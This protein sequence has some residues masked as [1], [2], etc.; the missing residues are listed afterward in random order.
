MRVPK[1]LTTKSEIIAYKNTIRKKNYDSTRKPSNNKEFTAEEDALI[2]AHRIT[3]RELSD[4]IIR[5]CQS[6][7]ARRFKIKSGQVKSNYKLYL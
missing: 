1:T 4:R 5:S 2:M 6:I 7:Q 3:D